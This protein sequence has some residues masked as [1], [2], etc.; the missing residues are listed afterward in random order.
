M[1]SF[2]AVLL[3]LSCLSGVGQ[4][5]RYAFPALAGVRLR[6]LNIVNG[7]NDSGNGLAYGIPSNFYDLCYD[8]ANGGTNSTRWTQWVKPQ[9]DA[10]ANAGA[11]CVRMTFDATVLVGDS[12]HHG[13]ANWRGTITVAQLNAMI[14]QICQY[15]AGKGMWFYATGTDSRPLNDGNLGTNAIC[16]YLSNYVAR[17]SLYD[18]VPAIDL[19][20]EAD[21]TVNG[22]NALCALSV[23]QFIAT[24]RQFE[25]RR[26]P[27]TCSLNGA[28]QASDLNPANRWQFYNLYAAGADFFDCHAYYLYYPADFLPAINNPW[29]LPV[30]I[31]ETGIAFWGGWGNGAAQQTNQPYSSELR[32]EFFDNVKALSLQPAF[33][34]V[35]VWAT[36][37]NADVDSENFGLYNGDQDQNYNFTNVN[38]WLPQFQAIP[39]SPLPRNPPWTVVCTGSNTIPINSYRE[40]ATGNAFIDHVGGFW[41]RQNNLIE[42]L[43]YVGV[44]GQATIGNDCVNLLLQGALSNGTNQTVSFDI[45]P[46]QT[47]GRYGTYVNWEA[48]LRQQTSGDNYMVQWVSDTAGVYDNKVEVFCYT[49]LVKTSLGSVQYGPGVGT[50]PLDLTQDWHLTAAV[51]GANPT[52]ISV[53]VS[54]VTSGI[55]MTPALLITNS[56]PTLQ[57]GGRTAA[58]SGLCVYLGTP[59]YTNIV[60]Q[61][62][63]DFTPV[64]ATAPAVVPAGA[65]VN[66]A[67]G[68]A[69]GGVGAVNYFPQY[70]LADV[71][72]FPATNF[73]SSG[74]LTAATAQTIT[75]LSPNSTY[76]FRIASVDSLN[77]TNYSPWQYATTDAPSPGG[78]PVYLPF[79]Y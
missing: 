18:N 56:A 50:Q 6:E 72:N 22:S 62:S 51:T 28:S 67:W 58:N 17:V 37:P 68:T 7:T 4:T 27:L 23:N 41:Q 47:Y 38:N 52:I 63:A 15:T 59:F 48:V 60:F 34:M 71:N 45:P 20:Q 73:W 39:K 70:V 57:N 77:I 79:R 29:N 76:I 33:Q 3:F 53:T 13:A 5:N 43:G 30:A 10:A 66:L 46:G 65:S 75:G 78:P 14:D 2:A 21:G 26:I 16:Q 9:I 64:L 40:V 55:V 42:G 12:T 54:N 61:N 1:R 69:D 49:N 8:W 32:R 74:A 36:V 31:G 24:A 25:Q 19:V 11:N 44:A 35:G